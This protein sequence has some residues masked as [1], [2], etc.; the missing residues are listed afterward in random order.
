MLPK[1]SIEYLYSEE[2]FVTVDKAAKGYWRTQTGFSCIGVPKDRNML[3][4]LDGCCAEYTLKNGDKLFA[5]S[6]D[7]VYCPI[8]CE[9]ALRFSN[10]AS[11]NSHTIGINF[12][13]YDRENQPFILA[14]QVTIF[15]TD[16][17]IYK[18]LFTKVDNYSEAAVPCPAKMKAAMYDILGNLSAHYRNK[19][20]SE[21]KYN[22]IAKGIT[23]LESDITQD[24]D[25]SEIAKM[26]NVSEV[27]FRKLFKQY[28]GVSPMEYKMD[29]KIA[30]A[31][32]YLQF[33]DL[34]IKEVADL[35]SFTDPTYFAKQFKK[36]C[37]MTPLQYRS[38]IK[39]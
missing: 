17:T 8:G 24:L 34:N 31:K 32:H 1:K 5:E 14:N 25:I 33:E 38:C 18:S 37:G 27:Y 29:M 3:L 39:K 15:Q 2:F 16:D 6:G 12:Y 28:A 23:H 13:L 7:I 9:Y 30:R 19:D 35:L 11:K 36:R 20:I 4:Y 22:I 10:F 21:N 26:C